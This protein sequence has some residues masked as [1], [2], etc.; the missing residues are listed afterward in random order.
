M[1]KLTQL[2]GERDELAS[3]LSK[4]QQCHIVATL[5]LK[6]RRLEAEIQN[7]QKVSVTELNQI[8]K[9]LYLKSLE[10][11]RREKVD[12]ENSLEHEQEALFNT[13]GKRL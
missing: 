4:D 10:Q 7:N 1:R 9:F 3:R 5:L 12:L 13:L 2:E 8:N 11:L 6:I